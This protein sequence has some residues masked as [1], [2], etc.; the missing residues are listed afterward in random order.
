MGLYICSACKR[1][2]SCST[3]SRAFSLTC[4]LP[5]YRTSGFSRASCKRAEV[6]CMGLEELVQHTVQML[7]GVL[8]CS[9]RRFTFRGQHPLFRVLDHPHIFLPGLRSDSICHD[10]HCFVV[11]RSRNIIKKSLHIADLEGQFWS[12][13]ISKILQRRF[14]VSVTLPSGVKNAPF[15]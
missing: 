4:S 14:M 10:L 5:F 9:F 8:P 11:G 12:R 7:G 3:E 1:F 13:S 15:E 6:V 2:S